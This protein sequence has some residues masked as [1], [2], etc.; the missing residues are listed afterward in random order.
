[1][2]KVDT[3]SVRDSR[4]KTKNKQGNYSM[5]NGMWRRRVREP[6]SFEALAKIVRGTQGGQ[7]M[8]TIECDRC[9]EKFRAASI[10]AIFCP[11][12]KELRRK[13]NAILR[14]HH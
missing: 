9:K 1:M 7:P 13:H 4:I 8:V 2:S 10:N 6:E 5:E 3:E 11:K 14:T 12:C